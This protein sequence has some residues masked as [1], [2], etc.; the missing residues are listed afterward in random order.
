M[1][2]SIDTFK[3]EVMRAA[4]AAGAGMINDIYGLRQEGRWTPPLQPAC[5]WC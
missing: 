4:V 2:I 3:P 1:P 5:R